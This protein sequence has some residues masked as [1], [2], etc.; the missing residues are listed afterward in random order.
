[1][2]QKSVELR[3]VRESDLPV[4]ERFSTEPETVGEYQ[5]MGWE[6]PG[7][8]RRQ[9]QE[10]GMLGEKHGLLMIQGDGEPAGFVSWREVI[11]WRGSS[12]WNT[13]ISLV[14]EARGRG[15]GA[16]AMR[17]LVRHLFSHTQMVR[18]EAATEVANVPAQRV[19]ERAGFTREG[20]LRSVAFRSGQWWDGVGY[21]VLRGDESWQSDTY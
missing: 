15:Y 2:T 3:P 11:C 17:Q 10:N 9:W 16:P 14:P 13:G 8:W 1:M 12:C 18:V 19:L 6:N 7:R 20:V 4:L 21:S 5:W